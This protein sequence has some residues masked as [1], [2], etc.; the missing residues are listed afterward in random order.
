MR[1]W[2]WILLDAAPFAACFLFVAVL[3]GFRIVPVHGQQRF[4]IPHT[5]AS[6]PQSDWIYKHH[7]AC[8]G[9]MDCTPVR[10]QYSPL[11]WIVGPNKV[12]VPLED[13]R[14]RRSMDE[15]NRPWACWHVPSQ[16][17][18]VRC[19]FLPSAGN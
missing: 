12:I 11:G 8:C 7:R 17:L 2:N 4:V 10:V 9:L 1:R 5:E 16:K 15:H 13:R 6:H 14:I 18:V 19:L 3:I